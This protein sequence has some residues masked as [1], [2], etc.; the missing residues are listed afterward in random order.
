MMRAEAIVLLKLTFR[1]F[2]CSC[3]LFGI[4]FFVLSS[5]TTVRNY[6]CVWLLAVQFLY[7]SFAL[8]SMIFDSSKLAGLSRPLLSISFSMSCVI[9][10]V[11]TCGSQ[12]RD[13][14]FK[15]GNFSLHVAPTLVNF[16][17]VLF[18]ADKNEASRA[19]G[20]LLS[21]WDIFVPVLV[22]LCYYYLF[23][24]E[25]S[26]EI[27][28]DV[29]FGSTVVVGLLSGIFVVLVKKWPLAEVT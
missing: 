22:M 4:W 26:Y 8:L 2:C 12:G 14:V 16:L 11:T 28:F 7:F 24:V 1:A 19:H 5:Y 23:F 18:C 25:D 20:F 9:T 10:Y 15:L 29:D 17:E 27:R 21:V 3:C 13:E 6:L